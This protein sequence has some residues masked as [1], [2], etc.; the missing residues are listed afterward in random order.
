MVTAPTSMCSPKKQGRRKT[1][2]CW[3]F[4]GVVRN[5]PFVEG[6]WGSYPKL[7]KLSRSQSPLST[8]EPSGGY[9]EWFNWWR[10]LR[11]LYR[12]GRCSKSQS[13][14]FRGTKE[15]T[16]IPNALQTSANQWGDHLQR[17]QRGG[18]AKQQTEQ[19]NKQTNKQNW[20]KANTWLLLGFH[21]HA[22]RLN[23]APHAWLLSNQ[24][25]SHATATTGC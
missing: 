4:G 24:T 20:R 25:S 1:T 22:T 14:L 19:Q 7:Q 23:N 21:R 16:Q 17:L 18:P 5:A 2:L 13:P 11:K 10:A 3:G 12:N 9:S 8:S 15:A 6:H